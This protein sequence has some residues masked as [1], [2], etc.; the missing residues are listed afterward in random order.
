M[1]DVFLVKMEKQTKKQKLVME[2]LRLL[3]LFSR[4]DKILNMYEL[5]YLF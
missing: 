3:L 5:F 4:D 2:F 1:L